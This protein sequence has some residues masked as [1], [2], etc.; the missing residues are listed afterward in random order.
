M[1]EVCATEKQ[2]QREGDRKKE[3][4]KERGGEMSDVHI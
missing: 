3:G 4:K 2:K 1:M